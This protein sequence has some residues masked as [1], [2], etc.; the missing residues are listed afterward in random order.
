MNKFELTIVEMLCEC[1]NGYT[2][3]VGMYNHLPKIVYSKRELHHNEIL[4]ISKFELLDNKPIF[5]KD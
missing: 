3:Y 5:R 4:L 2:A 1:K